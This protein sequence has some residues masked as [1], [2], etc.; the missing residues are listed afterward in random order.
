M[1]DVVCSLCEVCCYSFVVCC[2]LVVVVGLSRGCVLILI[3]VVHCL[4]CC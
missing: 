1:C 3:R 2:G 4:Y